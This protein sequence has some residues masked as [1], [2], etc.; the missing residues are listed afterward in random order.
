M[1]GSIVVDLQ[2]VEKDRYSHSV[3]IDDRTFV[4]ANEEI[5]HCCSEP[6]KI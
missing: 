4:T 3:T 6:E 5:A 1:E 2:V